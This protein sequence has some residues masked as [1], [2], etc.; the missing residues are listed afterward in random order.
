MVTIS[1]SHLARG[2]ALDAVLDLEL[3]ALG[4]ADLAVVLALHDR[5]EMEEELLRVLLVLPAEL[6]VTL[7]DHL[8]KGHGPDAPLKVVAL[9][10]AL[11][12]G[13]RA[14]VLGAHEAGAELAELQLEVVDRVHEVGAAEDLRGSLHVSGRRSLTIVQH[15]LR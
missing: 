2:A 7:A 12:L 5:A 1:D 3:Q 11:L 4:R 15:V 10:L 13:E 14:R 8:L 9:E 6:R